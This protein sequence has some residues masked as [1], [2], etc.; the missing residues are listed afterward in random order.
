MA[1]P[2]KLTYPG[3]DYYEI[4]IGKY[5]ERM[6]SDLPATTLLGYRQTNTTDATVNKFHYLGPLIIATKG[7]PVRIKF[8]NSLDTGSGGD[9]FVPVDT[10]IMGAGPFTINYDPETK[11]PTA[12]IT[13]DFAQNRADLHLHG[14]RS[15]W[16]SDGTP[17]Q[18]ITPAGEATAYPK[19]VSVAYVPDMWFTAAGVN[20]TD[21]SCAGKTTC[22][23]AGATNNPGPGKQT[24]YW[25]NQQSARLMFFHD[26]AWGITRL[27]VYVG[28]AAGYLLTDATETRSG[29]AAPHRADPPDH[30]G[31]DLRRRQCKPVVL[32]PDHGSNLALGQ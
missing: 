11:Q 4:E 3:S 27:N 2:D 8:T 13:G 22:S 9:L 20:I 12:T 10:S 21:P 17:H 25:S 30:S 31:Q 14:G 19:G 1:I 23:V 16:I 7:T 5:T 32:R 29:P 18:W 26:H 28:E 15:P 6:H 24:Y